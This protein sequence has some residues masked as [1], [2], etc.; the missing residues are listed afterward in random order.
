MKRVKGTLIAAVGILLFLIAY[1]FD[2]SIG[3]FF[4]NSGL[5]FLDLILSII[6]NFGVVIIAMLVVPSIILYKKNKKSVSLL[7]ITFL[8]SIVLAFIIKLVVLRQRPIDTFA[9]PFTN[10]INYSFPSMHS[11]VAFALLPILIKNLPRQK[12]F[13]IIFA[14]LVAFT[15]VYFGFHFLSDIVFGGFLG[16][17]IG[18]FLLEEYDKK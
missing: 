13:W 17:F 1:K 18:I 15:R 8:I 2:D 7:F 12:I 16:Y 3:L 10:I 4:K 14:F 11:M 5:Q 6:T 9:Y